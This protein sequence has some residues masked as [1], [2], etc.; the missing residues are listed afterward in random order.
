MG[1]EDSKHGFEEKQAFVDTEEKDKESCNKVELKCYF[2]D[3]NPEKLKYLITGVFR[4]DKLKSLMLIIKSPGFDQFKLWALGITIMVLLLWV[5]ALQLSTLG[6]TTVGPTA[7]KF[8][9]PPYNF[10]PP[11][12][13]H[14]SC[15]R[16]SDD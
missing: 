11:S 6:G 8:E 1:V 14:D 3:M 2:G 15:F 4:L 5:S 13:F 12:K 16:M 7:V 10:P 9:P